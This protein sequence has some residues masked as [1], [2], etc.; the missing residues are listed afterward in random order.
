MF[1]VWLLCIRS[2]SE[3][4]NELS[5]FLENRTEAFID[6]LFPLLAKI[7]TPPVP[8]VSLPKPAPATA[9]AQV[10]VAPVQAPVVISSPTTA[11]AQSVSTAAPAQPPANAAKQPEN[12]DD[13]AARAAARRERFGAV[14][15]TSASTTAPVFSD[16]DIS[17]WSTAA[18]ALP[19]RAQRQRALTLIDTIRS[20]GNADARSELVR[21]LAANAPAPAQPKPAPK[22]SEAPKS[23]PVPAVPKQSAPAKQ[24]DNK[25]PRVISTADLKSKTAEVPSKP[26][27]A[28]SQTQPVKSA[29]PVENVS[30]SAP[31]KAEVKITVTAPAADSAPTARRIKVSRV[32]DGEASKPARSQR[33]RSPVRRRS[34]SRS[35]SR[36]T[37]AVAVTLAALVL[38]QPV[39]RPDRLCHNDL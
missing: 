30:K 39:C 16:S 4:N 23:E 26:A 24:A 14:T 33:S 3:L 27:K 22:P 2:Q 5:C 8:E 7:Q 32:G 13:S 25:P 6:W 36:A 15:V 10:V 28:A 38:R 19:T 17:A 12:S 11:S 29:K 18:N 20:A 34:R 1:L 31:P 21:F 35:P 37:A 9:P